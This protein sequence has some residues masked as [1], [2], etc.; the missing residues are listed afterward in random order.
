MDG[1]TMRE[2]EDV[3]RLRG[4]E[5]DPTTAPTGGS[6][7]GGPAVRPVE[8]PDADEDEATPPPSSDED[9]A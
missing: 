8:E 2:P 6:V 1:R 9:R 7:I 4:I 3:E 5:P